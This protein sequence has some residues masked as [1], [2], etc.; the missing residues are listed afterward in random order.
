MYWLDT[1][2]VK[3]WWTYVLPNTNAVDFCYVFFRHWVVLPICLKK[4]SK[5]EKNR[6]T[7]G[8]T[9]IIHRTYYRL[10]DDILYN[11]VISLTQKHF[12]KSEKDKQHNLIYYKSKPKIGP[13]YLGSPFLKTFHHRN[14]YVL[15]SPIERRLKILLPFV[16]LNLNEFSCIFFIKTSRPKNMPW[17]PNE[18]SI[19]TEFCRILTANDE[20]LTRGLKYW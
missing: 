5:I 14:F 1:Y 15:L 13:K 3:V 6:V 16:I 7:L 10:T 18:H 19:R 20:K 2:S 8:S 9:R 11:L 12:L 4:I 17:S